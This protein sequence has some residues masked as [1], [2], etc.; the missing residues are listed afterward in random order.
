MSIGRIT[1]PT[2]ASVFVKVNEPDMTYGAPGSFTATISLSGDA[3][4]EFTLL[5][6][7][8]VKNALRQLNSEGAEVTKETLSMPV[9]VQEDG[10]VHITAR[11]KAGGTNRKTG[12]EF[13][14][15]VSVVDVE[16]EDATSLLIGKGSKIKL[17][18]DVIPYNFKDKIGISLRL[19]SIQV[20]K[21]V[22]VETKGASKKST[23]VPF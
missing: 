5:M 4:D 3:A 9:R 2:G 23:N 22:E 12:E 10:S 6:S 15:S 21:L 17:S 20:V 18:A 16:G 1:T 13:F 8:H 7:S 14:N 19:K 11:V